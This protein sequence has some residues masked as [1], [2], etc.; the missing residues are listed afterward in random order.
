VLRERERGDLDVRARA[1]SA[2]LRNASTRVRSSGSSRRPWSCL[3]TL[4]G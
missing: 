1:R 4:V 3:I 2:A